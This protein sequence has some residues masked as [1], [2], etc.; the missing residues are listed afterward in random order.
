VRMPRKLCLCKMS[1]A[2]SKRFIFSHFGLPIRRP[3]LLHVNINE[4]LFD[5]HI[6]IFFSVVDIFL[7]TLHYSIFMIIVY[8]EW[9][10]PVNFLTWS[11]LRV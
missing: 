11:L 5:I 8:S 6:P 1:S 9:K 10:R 3:G 7:C 4:V 2:T